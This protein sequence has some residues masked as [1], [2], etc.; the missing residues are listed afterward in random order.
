MIDPGFRTELL[1]FHVRDI[2]R[3]SED[4]RRTK[5]RSA[6]PRRPNPEHDESAS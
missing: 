6:S 3:A 4:H 2:A 1:R 5:R